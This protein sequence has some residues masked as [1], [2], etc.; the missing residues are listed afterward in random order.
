MDHARRPEFAIEM[1]VAALQAIRAHIDFILLA[2][3]GGLFAIFPIAA[4]HVVSF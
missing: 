4:A 1:G 3:I 2:L